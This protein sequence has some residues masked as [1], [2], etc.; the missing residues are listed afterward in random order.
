MEENQAIGFLGKTKRDA[1]ETL[2]NAIIGRRADRVAARVLLDAAHRLHC[3]D[4]H[5][6]RPRRPRRLASV[7]AAAV[8]QGCSTPRG[9]RH[10]LMRLR[11]GCEIDLDSAAWTIPSE[12]MEAGRE[13]RAALSSAAV[14]ILRTMAEARGLDYVFPSLQRDKPLVIPLF[15]PKAAAH[16]AWLHSPNGS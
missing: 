14:E 13:H 16:P 4:A 2:N 1:I 6:A 8:A 15:G 9:L 12:L 3:P 10:Q 5:S 11:V 7:A